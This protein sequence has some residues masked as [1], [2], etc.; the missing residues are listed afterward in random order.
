MSGPKIEDSVDRRR[1][2]ELVGSSWGNPV[3][4]GSVGCG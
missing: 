2:P 1:S 3:R 4:H